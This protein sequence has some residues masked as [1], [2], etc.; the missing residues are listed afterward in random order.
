MCGIVGFIDD[1]AQPDM[2]QRLLGSM[3]NRGPDGD[4]SYREGK[5]WMGMR[6]LSVIDLEGGSQ[7]LFGRERRVVAFQNGEIYNH[8]ELRRELEAAG[9]QFRTKSDTESLA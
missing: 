8:Q 6:R 4:G 2:L 9:Y 1:S 7:P 3:V 5:L